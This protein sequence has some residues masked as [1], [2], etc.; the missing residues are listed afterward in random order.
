MT[1]NNN[2]SVWKHLK[3]KIHEDRIEKA[4]ERFENAGF[5]PVLIKGWAA[6]QYYTNPS[7]RQFGDLDLV[8]APEEFDRAEKLAEEF[9]GELAIDLHRGVR[10][11]DTVPFN[12]LYANSQIVSCGKKSVRV[13]RREDHLRILCVHWLIDGGA[14]KDKLWDI[15]H[16]VKNRPVD[17]DWEACLDVVSTTRRRWII[18]TIFLA[19]KYLALDLTDTPLISEKIVVPRWL[20]VTLE[21]EWR[22]GNNLFPMHFLLNDPKALWR[23]IRKR[24]PPNPIQATVETEGEFDERTRILYQIGNICQRA[25]PSIKRIFD[26]IKK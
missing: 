1:A 21:K 2:L 16:A 15:Y 11:L 6:A 25:V 10:H 24:F 9:V 23:Q 4:W 8:F 7:D 19:H 12:I 26:Q 3:L 5:K 14:K 22:S 17:F 20:T 18:C 13:L